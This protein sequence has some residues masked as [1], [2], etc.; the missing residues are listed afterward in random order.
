MKQKLNVKNIL[1]PVSS[2]SFD[3]EFFST[4]L[5]TKELEIINKCVRTVSIDKRGYKVV[6]SVFYDPSLKAIIPIDQILK[7]KDAKGKFDIV[8]SILEE[9]G[10]TIGTLVYK[11]CNMDADFSSFLFFSYNSL[12][13]FGVDFG[14]DKE[15]TINIF[16]EAVLY[17]NQAI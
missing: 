9:T 16:P 11:A 3:V 2:T 5:S 15:I 14:I 1:K 6:F 4:E 17:N 10:K 7:L 8:I 13:S 12:N